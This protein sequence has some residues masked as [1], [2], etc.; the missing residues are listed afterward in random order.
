MS[1]IGWMLTIIF[2]GAFAAWC[3]IPRSLDDD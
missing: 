3:I 2:A 1:D